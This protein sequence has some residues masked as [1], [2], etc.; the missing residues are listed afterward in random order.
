MSD[1]DGK[2]FVNGIVPDEGFEVYGETEDGRR[3]PSLSLQ[4]TPGVTV[5]FGHRGQVA[6][7]ELV[8]RSAT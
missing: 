7:S 2:F 5:D 8:S 1:S 3:S 6:T 4:A